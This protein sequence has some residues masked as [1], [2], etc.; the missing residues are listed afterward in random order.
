MQSTALIYDLSLRKKIT[1]VNQLKADARLSKGKGGRGK[2]ER[3]DSE[4]NPTTIVVLLF[5]HDNDR[6]KMDV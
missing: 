6:E 2:G 3:G 5:R 1:K 4:I